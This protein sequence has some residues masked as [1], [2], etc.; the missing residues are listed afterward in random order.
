[1]TTSSKWMVLVTVLAIGAVVYDVNFRTTYV[2]W[3]D[4]SGVSIYKGDKV[5]VCLVEGDASK[6][7]YFL[8][9]KST[10]ASCTNWLLLKT[11]YKK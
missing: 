5:R 7:N 2:K 9:D 11:R 10:H 4:G 1:M 3:G 6:N 8:W